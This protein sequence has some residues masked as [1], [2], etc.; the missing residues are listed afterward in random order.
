MFAL[1]SLYDMLKQAS[2]GLAR[3]L[4]ANMNFHQLLFH[5]T[6][7]SNDGEFQLSFF[8]SS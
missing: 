4:Q 7:Y 6:C 5:C 8:V 3:F 1:E 2:T